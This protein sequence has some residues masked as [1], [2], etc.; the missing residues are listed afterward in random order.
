MQGAQRKGIDMNKKIVGIMACAFMFLSAGNSYAGLFARGGGE[1]RTITSVTPERVFNNTRQTL[2]LSGRFSKKQGRDRRVSIALDRLPTPRPVRVDDW[3]RGRIRVAIPAAMQP[4]RYH[5]FLERAYR[6]HGRVQW[7]RISNQMAFGIVGSAHSNSNG[8]PHA[9]PISMAARS[10]L[11][12]SMPKYTYTIQGG[13]F[14]INGHDLPIR[15]QL[16]TNPPSRLSRTASVVP[17]Q[18]S[19]VSP[20]SLRVEIIPSCL[21]FEPSL[22]LRLSY[23]DGSTSNWIPIAD[24]WALSQ[25]PRN[26]V[27]TVRELH[28]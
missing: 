12:Y 5:I 10:S 4:G 18:V 6:N 3:K 11:C 24:P 14:Q 22:E 9:A 16:R 19:V 26:T 28:R 13:P 27:G 15:A 8:S 23:P 25:R 1:S 20:T 7:R 2:V 17:P 21:V